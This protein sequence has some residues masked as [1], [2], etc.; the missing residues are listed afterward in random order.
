VIALVRH[1]RWPGRPLN[2]GAVAAATIRETSRIDYERRVGELREALVHLRDWRDERE[3]HG[4][5]VQS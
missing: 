5:Q 2:I 4:R 3:T 1:K